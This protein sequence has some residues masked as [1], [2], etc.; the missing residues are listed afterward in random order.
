MDKDWLILDSARNGKNSSWNELF[1]KHRQ[2]LFKIAFL[3]TGS[4]DKSLDIVQET[5]FSLIR[6]KSYNKDGSF[7]AYISKITYNCAL[8]LLQK[9]KETAGL[10]ID[11]I[12]DNSL[13]P[14]AEVLKQERDQIIAKIIMSLDSSQR[15]TLILRFYGQHSYEEIAGITGTPIGTVKSRIFYAVKT[16]RKELNKKGIIE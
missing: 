5:L 6:V 11:K 2:R 1:K 14:M 16:C 3:M 7:K 9:Q 4:R 10:E 8:K 15:E 13:S 12:E